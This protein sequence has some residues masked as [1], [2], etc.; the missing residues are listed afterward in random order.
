MKRLGTSW[1]GKT[2]IDDSPS[3]GDFFNEVPYVKTVHP[4]PRGKDPIDLDFSLNSVIV[5]SQSCDIVR[6]NKL[7]T[8]QVAPVSTLRELLFKIPALKDEEKLESLRR[9]YIPRYHLLNIN[10]SKTFNKIGYL[11]VDFG[12]VFSI[13]YKT[14]KSLV[15]E[16]PERLTLISPY[17]E[18]LSQEFARFYMRVG[19]DDDIEP[20][21]KSWLR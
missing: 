13:S 5:L 8:V 15:K 10:R 2:N 11:V 14:L 3:Q 12:A 7:K 4:L 21:N 6:P 20:L 9:N 19:L 17:R 18:R 1:Y 16:Q